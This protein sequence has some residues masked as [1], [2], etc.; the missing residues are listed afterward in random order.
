VRGATVPIRI[1]SPASCG[2]C[3]GTGARAGTVPRVCPVCSGTGLIT[4][5]QGAFALSEPCRDCR[6]MGRII[7]DPCAECGG[8]GVSNRH[9]TLTM[10]IPAG[11]G[12]GQRIRLAGQGEAG[13]RGAPAGDLY[14]RVHVT[15]HDVF[16]RSGDDLTLNV[17]VS[18]PELVMGTTLTVPT[19]DGPEMNGTVSLKVPAG[20]AHGRTFRVRGK[21]ITRKD[22]RTGDLLVTLHVEVPTKLDRKAKDALDAYAKATAGQ[23]PRADLF[24]RAQRSSSGAKR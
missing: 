6:G 17:P 19:M 24:R 23:D 5:S 9:R 12:D 11:V 20:T 7:D 22:G 13:M 21:G 15:P 14:V 1:S 18:F 8:R 10:R 2:S 3:G 16:G 4:R